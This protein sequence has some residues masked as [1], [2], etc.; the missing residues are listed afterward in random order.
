[1]SEELL[2][3][4][5]AEH[6]AAR[7]APLLRRGA[8]TARPRPQAYYAAPSRQYDA[9]SKL[10]ESTHREQPRYSPA[11][12]LYPWVDLQ[13]DGKIRSLY[14]EEVYEPEQ[15]IEEAAQTH[16]RREQLR[17][18]TRRGGR[19]G[20]R[21]LQLRARLPVVVRRTPSRCAATCTTSSPASRVQQLPRQHAVLRLPGLLEVVREALREVARRRGFEPWRGKGP[22][23]RATLYF[24][25]AVSGARQLLGRNA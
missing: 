21:A 24:T 13:P 2:Q 18:R 5:L 9:L 4:A 3:A 23:A 1:M 10:L 20:A 16:E 7:G 6:A 25:A 11:V 8:P 15:L 17:P 14:T 19:R 22:A 12:Q